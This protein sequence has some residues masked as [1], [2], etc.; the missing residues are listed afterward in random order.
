MNHKLW[1]DDGC[2]NLVDRRK[3]AKLLWLRNPRPV[4]RRRPLGRRRPKWAVN[5]VM[6]LREIKWG[7]LGCL[8]LA[9][10]K[11]RWRPLV[12]VVI[13]LLVPHIAEKFFIGCTTRDHS[14]SAQLHRV[15][16]VMLLDS[17]SRDWRLLWTDT[18]ESAQSYCVR[19]SRTLTRARIPTEKCSRVLC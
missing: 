9:Q 6:D 15:S 11:G 1:L 4:V 10:N 2:S 17:W 3:V 7:G 8:D 12:S 13:T 5:T 16:C 14:S 18:R 19:V